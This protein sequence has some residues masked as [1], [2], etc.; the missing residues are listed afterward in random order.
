MNKK[1]LIFILMIVLMSFTVLGTSLKQSYI[2]TGLDGGSGLTSKNDWR[3]QKFTANST[4]GLDIF[5]L[6][7]GNRGNFDYI[8]V[9]I[10]NKNIS[11]GFPECYPIYNQYVDISSLSDTARYFNIT[12]ENQ[13]LIENGKDY[14]IVIHS[15]VDGGDANNYFLYN[16]KVGAVG[17]VKGSNSNGCG[18]SIDL[19]PSLLVGLPYKIYGSQYIPPKISCPYKSALC[20]E[21]CNNILNDFYYVNPTIYNCTVFN[22][23]D[24][25]NI[26]YAN[27]YSCINGT[28]QQLQNGTLIINYTS[29]YG[30]T[31]L[32]SQGYENGTIPY[33]NT[34]QTS[35]IL[36]DGLFRLYNN[37]YIILALLIVL[38]IGVILTGIL[39]MPFIISAFCMIITSILLNVLGLISNG[40]LTILILCIV[41]LIALSFTIFKEVQNVK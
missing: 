23:L 6:N 41:L 30:N 36:P 27:D 20:I 5:T 9:Q 39:K 12:F 24:C 4:Y 22:L 28:P 15:L 16:Y 40:I 35:T 18:W 3:G 32:N 38:A 34:G 19:N 31:S 26:V 29:I 21:Q 8:E 14:Y 1:I 17:A 11:T 37:Y 10:R 33:I 13:T 7:I 2:F 25:V